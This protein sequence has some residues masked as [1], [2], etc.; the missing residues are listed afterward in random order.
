MEE[1]CAV[2]KKR[3]LSDLIKN[4]DWLAVWLG[5]LIIIIILAG[6]RP[7]M[8]SFKWETSGEF[9]ATVEKSKPKVEKFI[10]DAQ[11]K[12]ETAAAESATALK[13][14]LDSGDRAGI[15]SAAKK[16]EKLLRLQ[17]MKG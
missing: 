10:A 9:A 8:P 3:G 17:K 1:K 13:A 12:N 5:F 7:K 15:G 11:A 4:E 14:A 2:E 16:L 6:V